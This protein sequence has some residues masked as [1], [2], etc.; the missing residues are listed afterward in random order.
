MDLSVVEAI[1]YFMSCNESSGDK[2]FSFV[3][4]HVDMIETGS[5]ETSHLQRGPEHFP[6]IRINPKYIKEI[7]KGDLLVRWGTEVLKHCLWHLLCGHADERFD[8][9]VSQYGDER[10]QAAADLVVNKYANADIWRRAEQK[11]V[12]P[13]DLNLP[14]DETLEFYVSKLADIPQNQWPQPIGQVNANFSQVDVQDFIQQSKCQEKLRGTMPSEADEYIEQ[15]FKPPQV[16]WDYYLKEKEGVH[17]G[18][19]TR[20]AKNRPSRRSD[21]HY[22]RR[23]IGILNVAFIVDTSGSMSTEDLQ[24]VG[25]EI[26]GIAERGGEI[27]ILHCDAG[28]GY[29]QKYEI[30]MD[31]GQFYGRGGT[32]FRPA[33]EKLTEIDWDPDFVVYFTDGYGVAPEE[34]IYD[35]LWVLTESGMTEEDFKQQVCK[36]GTVCK[37]RNNDCPS[38]AA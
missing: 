14:D 16:D 17:R 34:S 27:M 13:S 11:L 26:D 15:L 1:R 30:G 6:E 33:F 2:D 5:V 8:R 4:H 20:L 37:I 24:I 29:I 12:C 21:W 23:H 18:H 9:L 31:L 25:P 28:V 38:A 22:G 10:C 19:L 36:W 35:T 32:D 3:F 7:G